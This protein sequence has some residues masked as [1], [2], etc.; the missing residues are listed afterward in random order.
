LTLSW[1]QDEQLL[2]RDELDCG[3][4][5][6]DVSVCADAVL[7]Y[8]FEDAVVVTDSDDAV[9]GRDGFSGKLKREVPVAGLRAG[10]SLERKSR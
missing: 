1:E 8:E 3:D 7:V 4:A 5:G 6:L 10:E 9:E 2:E